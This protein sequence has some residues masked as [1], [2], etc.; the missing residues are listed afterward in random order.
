[1]K[2]S[3][4][5]VNFNQAEVTKAL[6]AS[7]E[8]QDYKD[9]ELIVV[10]NGSKRDPSQE[11]ITEFP[12]IKVIRSEQNLGFAGGNNL[13]IAQAKGEYLFFLNNDTEVPNGTIYDLVSVLDSEPVVG[14]VNP[15]L[16]YHD[17]CKVQFAG[18]TEIN[19]WTARNESIGRFEDLR[20]STNLAETP[21]VH[22]AAMM[23]RRTAIDVAGQMPEAYFLY[24]EELDWGLSLK[25]RGFSLK[26]SHRSFITHKESVS[27]GKSSP[28]KTYFQTRN[29]ILFM[30]RNYSGEKWFFF[31]FFG[32]LALPKN[33]LQLTWRREWKLLLA[34]VQGV[35]WNFQNCADSTRLGFGYDRLRGSASPA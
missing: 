27:T 23:V 4:I 34:F 15:I 2:V 14:A 30:R 1:M 31:L 21:F 13:G 18:Y 11:L 19:R 12:W 33:I 20:L 3:I 28:L 5:T 8:Q 22:G 24:Y 10:D 25:N 7:L 26:V 35:L 29:R 32:L 16:V 6:I 17:T 9:F